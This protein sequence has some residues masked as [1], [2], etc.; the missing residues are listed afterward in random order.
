MALQALVGVRLSNVGVAVFRQY[1]WKH[2]RASMRVGWIA[3]VVLSLSSPCHSRSLQPYNNCL[4]FSQSNLAMPPSPISN[5]YRSSNGFLH[6]SFWPFDRKTR[7]THLVYSKS[8][9][10]SSNLYLSRS[11]AGGVLG[12]LLT[13]SWDAPGSPGLGSSWSS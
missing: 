6:I 11:L 9:S 3:E 8:S 13:R 7:T 4:S 2:R 5:F 10:L 1:F 12:I